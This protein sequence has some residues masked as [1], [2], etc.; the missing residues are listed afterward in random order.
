MKEQASSLLDRILVIAHEH[1]TEIRM[2]SNTIQDGALKGY[3]ATDAR[4]LQDYAKICLMIVKDATPS[5]TAFE[6]SDEELLAAAQAILKEQDNV[7][8]TPL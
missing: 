5:D 3:T 6:G 7:D 8:H 1:V 4:T 2:K